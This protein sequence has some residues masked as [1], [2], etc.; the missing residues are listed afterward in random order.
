MYWG[1]SLKELLF[2]LYPYDQFIHHPKG[3]TLF[4]YLLVFF[5]YKEGLSIFAN[6][7]L[8]I[9]GFFYLFYEGKYQLLRKVFYF[10]SIIYY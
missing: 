9:S 7:I 4:Q 2:G 8:L 10:L 5:S 6:N 3:T 1:L